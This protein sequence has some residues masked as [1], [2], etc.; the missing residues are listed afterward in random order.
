MSMDSQQNR[1]EMH[2]VQ[3]LQG[4]SVSDCKR[5]PIRHHRHTF[6]NVKKHCDRLRSRAAE[7]PTSIQKGCN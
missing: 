7:V 6:Q 2:V 4:S 1:H 3:A 5:D